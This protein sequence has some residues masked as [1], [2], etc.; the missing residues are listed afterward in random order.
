MKYY[1]TKWFLRWCYRGA[2]VSSEP[3]ISCFV[4]FRFGA[5]VSYFVFRQIGNG[6]RNYTPGL[7][8]DKYIIN[9]LIDLNREQLS[10]QSDNNPLLDFDFFPLF[11]SHLNK[12][13]QKTFFWHFLTVTF[14]IHS[15]RLWLHCFLYK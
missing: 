1:A 11:C 3:E 10:K 4:Y 5:K 2:V 14:C 15:I 13:C 7:H 6:R 8:D 9:S 12:K